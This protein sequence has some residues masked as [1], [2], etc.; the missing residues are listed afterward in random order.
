M[1]R[2]Q[3]KVAAVYDAPPMQY[4]VAVIIGTNF[5]ANIVQAS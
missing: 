4:A 5:V 3:A 2:W 1:R